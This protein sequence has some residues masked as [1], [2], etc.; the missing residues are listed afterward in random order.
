MTWIKTLSARDVVRAL[1][2][3]VGPAVV[4]AVLAD[5]LLPSAWGTAAPRNFATVIVLILL[6]S[7]L[8]QILVACRRKIIIDELRGSVARLARGQLVTR[9]HQH[10][11]SLGTLATSINIL[12]E[13]ME[14]SVALHGEE[15]EQLQS[16]LSTAKSQIRSRS[17]F[18][19]NLSCEL[20]G[21]LNGILGMAYL[22]KEDAAPDV[23]EFIQGIIDSSQELLENLSD[24]SDFSSVEA[25]RIE[26]EREPFGLHLAIKATIAKQVFPAHRKGLKLRCKIANNVP[27][28]VI[29]D[30]ERFR[31]VLSSF[32]D[33]AIKDTDEG[34]ISVLATVSRES[35]SLATVRI[36]VTDTGQGLGDED[37]RTS[38]MA[39]TATRRCKPQEARGPASAWPCAAIWRI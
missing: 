27:Y 13:A 31:Q 8:L 12:A 36:A 19:A 24:L 32:L 34:V 5:P 14:E 3:S 35:L 23:I 29:G 18:L 9:A 39:C 2:L 4:Y 33:N 20:R 1:S 25:G 16:E 22:A 37:R 15:V 26:I 38:S 17:L 11:G 7:A 6:I 28:K 10:R 21:R 30:D